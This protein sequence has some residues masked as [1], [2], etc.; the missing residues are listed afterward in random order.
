MNK[1][2]AENDTHKN[3]AQLG[4]LSCKNCQAGRRLQQRSQFFFFNTIAEDELCKSSHLNTGA[5]IIPALDTTSPTFDSSM[6]NVCSTQLLIEFADTTFHHLLG[7]LLWLA[8]FFACSTGLTLSGYIS[9]SRSATD[10]QD[11]LQQYASRVA[12]LAL[13][14]SDLQKTGVRQEHQYGPSHRQRMHIKTTAPLSTDIL[15]IRH[16]LIFSPIVA[17]FCELVS[18]ITLAWKIHGFSIYVVSWN[19]NSVCCKANSSLRNEICFKFSSTSAPTLPSTRKA[20]SP[21]Q[22][23]G[24]ILPQPNP[25]TQ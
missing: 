15:D 19:C 24:Q 6:T 23:H 8:W 12:C 25:C 1:L 14:T 11:L 7:N 9:A 20:T 21:Q 2:S 22:Q 18:N 13:L 16:R 10:R 17:I 5:S 4:E 3:I